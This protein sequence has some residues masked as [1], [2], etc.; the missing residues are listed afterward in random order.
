MQPHLCTTSDL[1]KRCR[2][3][4]FTV[5]PDVT[6]GDIPPRVAM[7]CTELLTDL[8]EFKAKTHAIWRTYADIFKHAADS[9]GVK[10]RWQ[11]LD[12]NSQIRFKLVL[13]LD[14]L[15]ANTSDVKHWT[16]GS[17]NVAYQTPLDH[18]W[19]FTHD[20]ARDWLRDFLRVDGQHENL[21]TLLK[22]VAV[23]RH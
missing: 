8:D 23:C 22:R 12:T 4:K 18:L 11:E 15:V 20:E 1:A 17:A 13:N 6:G 14:F 19:A 16:M 9:T 5:H 7:W 2:Q 3:L 10:L 21:D